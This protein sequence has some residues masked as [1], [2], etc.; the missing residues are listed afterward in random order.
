MRRIYFV[1]H[2]ENIGRYAK[3][4]RLEK[5][6]KILRLMRDSGINTSETFIDNRIA[7]RTDSEFECIPDPT[8][9]SV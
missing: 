9:L 1:D 5:L 6:R 7:T 3:D 8:T 4:D 2:M